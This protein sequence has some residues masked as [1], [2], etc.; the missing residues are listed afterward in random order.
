[1]KTQTC[2]KMSFPF[3]VAGAVLAG[4]LLAGSAWAA[5]PQLVWTG[6]GDGTKW[7]DA[8]NWNAVP[9][10]S[11]AN[12]LDFTALT[13]GATIHNDAATTFGAVTFGADRGTV[14]WT[15][16]RIAAPTD[17]KITI[18]TGTTLDAQF[19]VGGWGDWVGWALT[20]S[21]GG[22]LKID[23]QWFGTYVGGILTLDGVAARM[24]TG[25]SANG[26]GEIRLKGGAKL[27]AEA[28][29]DVYALKSESEADV[30]DL[31]GKSLVLHQAS[32]TFAG[33]LRGEGVIIPCGARIWTLSGNSPDF[34][35]RFEVRSARVN[36]TGTLG[37]K[38][39][40]VSVESGT[41]VV[42]SNQTVARLS[43]GATLGGIEIADGKTLTVTGG[44]TYGA[45]L[46]GAGTFALD[47]PGQTLTLSGANT[48]T[49]TMRVKAGTLVAADTVGTALSGYPAGLVS[50]YSFD[51]DLTTDELGANDLK[52]SAGAP[53]PTT[54]G[55]GGSRCARFD[56]AARM[57]TAANSFISGKMPFTISFWVRTASTE[58]WEKGG[59]FLNVGM[60][61]SEGT[62]E[63]GLGAISADGYA[64]GSLMTFCGNWLWQGT[65]QTG[66][67]RQ[68]TLTF[69]GTDAKVYTNGTLSETKTRDWD[70]S[71]TP[72]QLGT[73]VT[74]DYDE[75][76]VF[77]R[78]LSADEVKA[79]SEN[80]FPAP[81][82]EVSTLPA[83]VAHW[84]FNDAENPGKDTSGNGHDLEVCGET[85]N[86]TSDA[87]AFGKAVRFAAGSAY[88]KLKGEGRSAGFP[89]G[90]ASF[91][92]NVRVAGWE[93]GD[94]DLFS[95]GDVTQSGKAFRI[96]NGNYPRRIG[97][98]TTKMTG[99]AECQLEGVSG[100][101]I[102]TV[103]TFVH[104]AA[105]GTMTCYRDARP[106]DTV[107]NASPPDIAAQGT[108]YIAYNPAVPDRRMSCRLDDVQVFAE[109][110]DAAQVR[111]LLQTLETGSGPNPLSDSSVSVDEGA[112]FY[113]PVS[114]S[115]AGL[116]GAGAVSVGAH[117]TL[118]AAS[119][120]GFTGTVFG[121]GSLAFAENAVLA[122]TSET[123]AI[124]M[125]GP[126]TLPTVATVCFAE[127]EETLLA[128]TRRSYVVA[129]ATS[130]AGATDLSGW[131][132]RLNGAATDKVTFKIRGNAVLA[133][134]RR[135]LA[136][137][138]R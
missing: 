70:L 13:D 93:E 12:D 119:A 37:P 24:I 20:V 133:K 38:A 26:A 81:T 77:N 76:L 111:R 134:V 72:I 7:S 15:S 64:L 120:S 109:A 57:Q 78:A 114:T 5:N 22:T 53:T 65:W 71:S 118:A 58:T 66:D 125:T 115:I 6:G 25:M 42:S 40:V 8:N 52:V 127:S 96:C 73:N 137:V 95:M 88:L 79:L 9:N 92:V 116:T 34:M 126:L 47:A 110:L 4:G 54:G 36:V 50:R 124:D 48:L 23:A 21:G 10:W 56:G 113:T 91:T 102:Y 103:F 130:L 18:P 45:R 136:I 138:I 107:G 131:T 39:Q 105:N 43:D 11:E 55:I 117:G 19:R 33:A 2:R 44:G 30:F 17:G 14:T 98:S 121:P 122:C 51:C 69:D 112:S 108:V 94:A 101:G 3:V 100:D 31:G 61:S 85:L 41:F 87:D 84:A 90:G 35:G 97:Y 75:L 89:S 46:S 132:C 32:G 80:P 128:D 82:T 62:R 135:G 49:G 123:P 1:M 129:R 106:A 67:W 63:I 29:F 86:L 74:A 27:T 104:D 60:W 68:Y 16:D 59:L 83:P 28:N 99:G